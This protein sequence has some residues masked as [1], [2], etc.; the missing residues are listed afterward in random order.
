M[1]NDLVKKLPNPPNKY[2]KDAVKKYYENMNLEGKSFSLKPV[3]HASVLKLLQRINPSKSAGIDNLTGKFL[4]EQARIQ[5][6]SSGFWKPVTKVPKNMYVCKN[7]PSH[8]SIFSA[9]NVICHTLS[10]N[11]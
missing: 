6:G 9:P 5:S 3:S 11:L 7:I 2:G 8:N 10:V 1:A 4:K